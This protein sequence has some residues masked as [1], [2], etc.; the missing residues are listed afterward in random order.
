M[1][2]AL[3][4]TT[5]SFSNLGGLALFDEMI[6]ASRLRELVR[7]HLPKGIA[8]PLTSSYEK[9]RALV[10][11]FIA[12]ADCLDDLD[13]LAE[14]E[15]FAAVCKNLCDATTFGDYLRAFDRPGIRRLNE[16]LSTQ[17]LKIRKAFKGSADFILDIDSTHHEQKAKK[18]EGLGYDYAHRWCLSSLQAYDQFGLQYWMDVREGSASTANGAVTAIKSVMRKVPRRTRRLLRADSGYCMT[19]VFNACF[20]TN[21]KFVITMRQNMLEPLLGRIRH[22]HSNPKLSTKD[23]RPVEVGTALYRTKRGHETLRVVVM[24]ALK[25]QPPLFEDRHD[26]YAFITN[27][28]H[29]E[30]RDESVIG[31]YRQR[32]NAEN[33]IKELKNAHDMHHFPC[34]KLDAN[35]AY[36]IIAAFA[37]NLMRA[38]SMTL[39]DSRPRFYKMLRF[40]MVNLACQVVRTAR[41][42]TF[43]F[44]E[45][46]HKEVERWITIT[47]QQFGSG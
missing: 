40:R 3:E 45:R 33:Y 17:S 16:A 13:K 9:F 35:R 4:S 26:Y 10:F 47:H 7:E 43:R 11:A 1:S 39:S 19:D 20:E 22:W 24:R 37:Y 42:V 30:M 6:A 31:F 8:K 14:D 32:G 23:G 12:G 44:N 5:Q 38:A 25:P 29:H 27:I 34:K 2:I 46:L 41:R 18:M 28:G 36:G 15:G 21:T